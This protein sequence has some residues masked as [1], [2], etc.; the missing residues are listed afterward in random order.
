MMVMFNGSAGGGEAGGEVLWHGSSAPFGSPIDKQEE[1]RPLI[2][3]SLTQPTRGGFPAAW[4]SP[5]LRAQRAHA[6]FVRTAAWYSVAPPPLDDSPQVLATEIADLMTLRSLRAARMA[7]IVGQS[8]SFTSVY[9]AF[10]GTTRGRRPATQTLVHLGIAVGM[11]VALRWKAHVNRARPAQV[12]PLLAPPV[13]TP[14]H[15]AY[16]SGH[17]TQ[18]MLIARLVGAAMPPDLRGP[19]EGQLRAMANRIAGNREIAGLHYGSDTRAGFLLAD[20]IAPLVLGTAI[21]KDEILPAAQA[22]WSGLVAGDP[23][24]SFVPWEELPDRIAQ[25]V[26]TRLEQRGGGNG[27]G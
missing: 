5:L 10:L 9:T 4:W 27:G 8:E 13:A 26:V 16:P 23:P 19:M 20:A 22:E 14:P 17:A 12:F 7:E 6:E 1:S 3:A 15:P 25:R 11:T 21:V 2:L 18:T 24:A